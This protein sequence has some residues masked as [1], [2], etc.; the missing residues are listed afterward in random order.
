M[1]HKAVLKYG[2]WGV[3]LF[4]SFLVGLPDV[5]F[6]VV[7]FLGFKEETPFLVIAFNISK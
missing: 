2:I 4:V 7:L 3:V 1:L 6:P 5:S